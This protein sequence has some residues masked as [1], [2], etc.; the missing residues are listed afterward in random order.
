MS[1][2]E[3]A[4]LKTYITDNLANGFIRPSTSPG[5]APV[6]FIKKRDGKLKLCV[7]YRQLNAVTVK[8]RCPLPLI[9]ELLDRLNSATIFTKI[10]LRNA[11]HQLRVKEGEEYKTAFR[12]RYGQYEY[13]VCPF[14]PTN[15]PA[16]FQSFINDVFR[17]H[18]DVFLAGHFGN[19]R[20]HALVA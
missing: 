3:L 2:P 4:T 7:N 11:Y 8:N 18:L 1:E 19:A 6:M 5:G 9:P 20:T 16:A 14:E 17:E 12:C 10:D 15:A 13:Q